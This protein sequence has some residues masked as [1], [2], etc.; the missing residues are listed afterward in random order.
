VT[1]KIHQPVLQQLATIAPAI[2]QQA[3]EQADLA[4][5][6]T[7]ARANILYVNPAFTR[8][9][10]YSLEELIGSNQ[11]ILSNKCTPAALYDEMWALI[12]RGLP[13]SGRLINR[14]KDGSKY[15]ADLLITPVVDARGEV[16]SFLGIH[17]DVT[18]LHWLESEVA[19]QKALI[20]SVV[21]STPVVIALLD[22][23]D[24]VVLD[25]HEY[26]KL[27]GDLRMVEPA[28]L[29]LD[30]VRA[31]LGTSQVAPQD[32][33]QAFSDHEMRIDSP[34][35]T[36]WFSCSGIW[37][38]RKDSTAD[39][40]FTRRN[41]LYLLLVAKE[42]TRQRAEQEKTRMALLQA[43]MAEETH[44]EGLRETLSAAV[45]KIEGPINLMAS[46]MATLERR[47]GSAAGAALM[48]ALHAGREAV[49]SLR[50]AIPEHRPEAQT[51][52]NLNE[53]MRDVLDLSTTR[54][55]ATGISVQWRP[56]AVLPSVNA[57]PNRLRSM[58]KAL[59]DNA[60][61]AMNSKGWRQRELRVTTR[62]DK[63]SAEVVIEDSGPGIPADLRLKI[64]E[65]FF[66]TRKA[67]GRHLGTGLSSAQ[68]VA[69]DHDGVIEFEAPE[70]GGCRVRVALATQRKG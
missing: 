17:R 23:E 26:K 50:S 36:R 61:D 51:R 38:Q 39:A 67:D 52:V 63:G 40:F 30:T 42:T 24:K 20:E 54:M 22:A 5:S 43:M 9:T 68:Q 49:D 48:D 60:I 3:V 46:V 66:S 45:F 14:R 55:L 65:P 44:I 58:F 53:V 57:Y 37:V 16:V 1:T 28:T 21:D 35:G 69:A 27:M 62:G 33:R 6:I 59:I 32:G 10:G 7:D 15:L 56:Q 29:I 12:V 8:T 25:N 41:D 19:D 2:F 34:G 11:S 4:I 31:D 47:G 13:W 70:S 18:Q 64:F